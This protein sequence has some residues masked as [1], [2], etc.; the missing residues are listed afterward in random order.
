[1]NNPIPYRAFT[2]SYTSIVGQIRSDAVIIYG[3][4]ELQTDKALWDTGATVTC[5]S[6]NVVKYLNLI[7]TGFRNIQT[8]SGSKVVN[9]YLVNIKLP[10][11]LLVIDVPVCDSDIGDQGIDLLIGM[12]IITRGDFSISQFGGKT[13]FSFCVPSIEKTDF[14]SKIKLSQLIGK[15]HGKGK[16]KK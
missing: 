9:T 6:S 12:D 5:I 4:N 10:N 15:R 11:Q 8:P 3:S 7:R 14:V 13:T 1:M 16:R 2:T